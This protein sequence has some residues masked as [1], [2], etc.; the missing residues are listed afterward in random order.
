MCYI[1]TEKSLFF[2]VCLSHTLK[3]PVFW[4]TSKLFFFIQYRR[5]LIKD[6]LP[7]RI[8]GKN[9]VTFISTRLLPEYLYS[10]SL[11]F[12]T[13]WTFCGLGFFVFL[14]HTFFSYLCTWKIV[15]KAFSL[16]LCELKIFLNFWLILYSDLHSSCSFLKRTLLLKIAIQCK[17]CG[18]S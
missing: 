12:L 14:I 13:R 3:G 11:A 17:V 5:K 4:G 7:H 18:Q 6:K 10:S 2:H 9:S 16:K 8:F 15:Y 1:S